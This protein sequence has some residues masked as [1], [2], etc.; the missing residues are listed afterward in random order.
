[1]GFDEGQ[2]QERPV[3]RVY[4]DGFEMSVFQVRNQDFALFLDATGHA[5]PPYWNDPNFNAAG[6]PVVAVSW[7]EATKYGEWLSAATGRGYRLPTETE[8]ERAVRGGRKSCAY[9]WGNEPPQQWPEYVQRW[10]GNVTG[11]LPVGWGSPNPFGLYDIGENVHE[12]CADWFDPGYYA[13]SPERNPQGPAS[14]ARRA[15]RGG[16]WRHQIKVSRCAARSS[17]PP[18][19]KYAD[20]GFRVA[21]DLPKSES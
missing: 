19:F 6:Q 18:S 3:H 10:G 7:F 17:I 8:W 16:S 15:S 21:R 4:L 20:Y 2:D 1:M 9:P 5:A 11:P 13:C 12:W 14:G